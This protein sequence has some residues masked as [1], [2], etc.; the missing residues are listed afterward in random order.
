[1][2]SRRWYS[3]EQYSKSNESLISQLSITYKNGSATSTSNFISDL[4]L[5]HPGSGISFN[6]SKTL[7]NRYTYGVTNGLCKKAI[8]IGLN[9]SSA[10]MQYSV[11]SNQNLVINTSSG[12]IQDNESS[13]SSNLDDNQKN[14]TPFDISTVKDPMIKK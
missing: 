5:I 3:D 14:V 10:T 2:I 13:E 7:N 4:T 1:M 11:D 12:K 8:A 6:T 9:A